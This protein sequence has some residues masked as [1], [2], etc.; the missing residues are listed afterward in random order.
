LFRAGADWL[1]QRDM[2][3]RHPAL[4]RRLLDEA[5]RSRRFNDYLLRHGR[6][7]PKPRS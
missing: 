1:Q 7:W 6:V 3:A 4:A 2:A 5:D